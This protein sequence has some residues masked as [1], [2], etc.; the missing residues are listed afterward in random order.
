M[1]D[2][3]VEV[4]GVRIELPA[5][6]PILVLKAVQR[7]RYLPIWIGSS[8]SALIQMTQKGLI[9][10]RPLTHQLLL[11]VLDRY[12]ASIERV[13]V[14][15]REEHTFY[16]RIDTSDGKQISARPSDAVLLALTADAPVYVAE[17][18]LDED[19]IDAPEPDEDAVAQFREFLDHVSA[20]DFSPE[21]EADDA[22]E[23]APDSDDA[24]PDQ[25]AEP[26]RSDASEQSDEPDDDPSADDADGR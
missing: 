4:V 24:E 13:T 20:E 19:G 21:A 8:E 16:A 6:Q 7:P 25:A 17:S 23:P 3:E 10:A 22:A 18:V 26:D 1:A 5:N 11:D 14:T 2:L 15:G 9:S 12:G